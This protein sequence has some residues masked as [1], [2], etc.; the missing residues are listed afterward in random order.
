MIWSRQWLIRDQ[1]VF[2][3]PQIPTRMHLAVMHLALHKRV[4]MENNAD[5]VLYYHGFEIPTLI[6]LL[7]GDQTREPFYVDEICGEVPAGV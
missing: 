6:S 7:S 3:K 2:E 1:S 5:I 4:R